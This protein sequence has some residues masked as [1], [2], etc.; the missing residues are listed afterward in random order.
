MALY[1]FEQGKP[2]SSRLAKHHAENKKIYDEPDI[3]HVLI[4]DKYRE[5]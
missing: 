1:L 2:F 5:L 4:L 3:S